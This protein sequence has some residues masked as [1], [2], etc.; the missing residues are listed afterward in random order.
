[1]NAT[2]SF[3]QPSNGMV[4]ELLIHSVILIQ[5]P[6]ILSG[7]LHLILEAASLPQLGWLEPT[8][9]YSQSSVGYESPVQVQARLFCWKLWGSFFLTSVLAPLA[10]ADK[11]RHSLS[12]R[13]ITSISAPGTQPSFPCMSASSYG[14]LLSLSSQYQVRLRT[15]RTPVYY[16][17]TNSICNYPI[18]KSKWQ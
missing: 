11:P 13:Q 10:V 7:H 3:S 9:I 15:S 2:H 6:E 17:L 4:T 18:M 1:M 8:E 16:N 14:A 12:H 5:V